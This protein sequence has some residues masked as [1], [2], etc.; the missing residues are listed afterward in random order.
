[1]VFISLVLETDAKTVLN[2]LSNVF[3]ISGV[4]T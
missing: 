3:I 2:L 1:M 4:R